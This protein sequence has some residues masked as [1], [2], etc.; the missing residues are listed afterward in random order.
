MTCVSILIK[1]MGAGNLLRRG[2]HHLQIDRLE[3]VG[4][5][6][7]VGHESNIPSVTLILL[8]PPRQIKSWRISLSLLVLGE[9]PMEPSI[10]LK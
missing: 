3:T 8:L 5:S 2:I 9:V 7:R 1:L 4:F 10:R 6:M